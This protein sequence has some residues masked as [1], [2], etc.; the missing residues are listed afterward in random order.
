MT[1]LALT[2]AARLNVVESLEQMTLACAEAI[3]AGQS[4]RLDTS[5][6]RFTKANA[7]T[8]AEARA[9][10]MAVRSAAAGE[11]VTAIR[12]G[13]I[14]GYALAAL[15]YDADVFL[16]DTD[17][18]PADAPG[19][20][21]TV[22]GKVIP[23]AMT[24]LGTAQDKLLRV[25]YSEGG[26]GG[27]LVIESKVTLTSELLA[28]SVDKWVFIADRPYAVT[29][30]TEIHS[31]VGGSGA[32]LRPRKVTA[33]GT[34]APGAAAGATV[35]ELTAADID[36]TTTVNTTQTP[37]LTATGADLLLAVG[38]KI[39]LNLGG[40]LTGLVGQIVITLEPR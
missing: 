32:V 20:I 29:L 9:Y 34:D 18:M 39:G 4:V 23:G 12:R 40:T 17:G 3:V 37:A 24:A 13:V 38:D 26:G 1:D 31:V 33:A 15:N 30:V 36:L 5:T 14:D 16:S 28:A 21:T 19:E 8:V 35:K 7:T 25:D 10:G 22:I 27:G 6:G 11:G 2:T